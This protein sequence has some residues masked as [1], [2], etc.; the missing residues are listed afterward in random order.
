VLKHVEKS[1][2][3]PRVKL[4]AFMKNN[5][6]PISDHQSP[7]FELLEQTIR[8]ISP[9]TLVAPYL[10][11]GGTDAKYF[12]ELSDQVYRF[13]MVRLTPETLKTFHGINERIAIEDYLSAV[14]YFHQLLRKAALK[15]E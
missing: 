9:D 10:V 15:N 11:Q 2:N 6:S 8:E 1:I 14:Q 13:L 7:Q 5:P 4:E 12:Y 3:D